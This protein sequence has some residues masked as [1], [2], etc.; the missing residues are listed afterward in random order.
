M[1][2]YAGGMR[3]NC[4]DISTWGTD[5]VDLLSPTGAIVPAAL[6]TVP[7][8]V[9]PFTYIVEH[10]HRTRTEHRA[11]SGQRESTGLPQPDDW[12]ILH[13]PLVFVQHRPPLRCLPDS[14]HASRPGALP[15]MPFRRSISC[16]C[17]ESALPRCYGCTFQSTLLFLGWL[18]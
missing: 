12:F 4:Q 15:S 10:I 3:D 9:S 17:G 14:C 18:A 7:E 13:C 5:S 16:L 2:S 8:D 6:A 11:G 1:A